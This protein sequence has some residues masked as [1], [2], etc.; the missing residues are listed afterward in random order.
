LRNLTAKRGFDLIVDSAGGPSMDMAVRCLR[1]GGR[2]VIAGSTTGPK[3]ELDMRRVFW[4][5]L[6]VI[7]STMG[8]DVDVAD[9][10]RFIGGAKIKPEIDRTYGLEEGAEALTRLGDGERFGKVVLQIA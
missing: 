3:A 1:K 6:S 10:L 9:M 2:I 8:S 7:G 5:Q 4:N